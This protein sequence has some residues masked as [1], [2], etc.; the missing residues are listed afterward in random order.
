MGEA[1]GAP[2]AE[3]DAYLATVAP[4]MRAALQRL[5][6]LIRSAAPEAEEV[7]RY[8]MPAFRHHG[9]LVYY[10]GFSDHCSFYI[11][12]VVTQQE[13]A[14][15]LKPFASG[16]GTTRF[17]PDHPLPAALVRRIVKARVAE[18]RERARRRNRGP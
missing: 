17:T 8:R 16:K 15:E 13:F 2:P 6:S 11:G 9:P 1:V 12:S 14:K 3:I 4:E 5:R 10:A 18:N 7:I